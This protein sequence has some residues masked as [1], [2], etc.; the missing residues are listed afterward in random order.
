MSQCFFVLHII[1]VQKQMRE[2]RKMSVSAG[3]NAVLK[4]NFGEAECDCSGGAVLKK[5]GSGD[6][7]ADGFS[8][9]L[10][11]PYDYMRV[12]NV[13]EAIAE[14]YPHVRLSYIGNS[15][16][17]RRIPMLSLGD[18]E[19]SVFYIGTHHASEW[20]CAPVLLKFMYEAAEYEE[21]GGYVYG[22]SLGFLC[23][24]RS[25][26]VLPMLNVDGVELQ[27]H[28]NDPQNPLRERLVRANGGEDFTHWQ[29][30]GR[31]VDLNHNY[32]AGF[33]EYKAIEAA[34]G[35]LGAAPTRF[36]G[37]YAESEPECSAVANFLRYTSPALLLSL[38]TQGEV[39]YAPSSNKI[40]NGN[41][42]ADRLSAMTAYPLE[43]AHGSAAYGGLSDWYAEEMKL[44][45]Y[46]LECGCGENPLPMTAA[47]G[48]YRRIRQALFVSPM[49]V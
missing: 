38:H 15:L 28:G 21:K 7:L 34:S 49:L 39:I 16:L 43:K 41:A 36:S 40:K 3:D 24:Q 6:A 23:R 17:S 10:D 32:N 2:I 12:C 4:G 35:I 5:D 13:C 46:T 45:A 14:R 27:I 20:V 26:H 31:G 25:I 37:E 8:G 29:A 19:K 48:I 44:P 30:N 22:S 33:A 1:K 42:I 11:I 47:S 9:W 18:G